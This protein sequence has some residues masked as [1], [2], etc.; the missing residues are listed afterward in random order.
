MDDE[1]SEQQEP[2][3]DLASL[4]ALWAESVESDLSGLLDKSVSI[5]VS[6][7]DAGERD[8]LLGRGSWVCSTCRSK[9][10]DSPEVFVLLPLQSALVLAAAQ[11]GVE[12]A[13]F[14]TFE[15]KPFE[16]D[17]EQGFKDAMDVCVGIL[18]RVLDE[19][20]GLPALQLEES[21]AIEAGDG[22]DVPAAGSYRRARFSFEIKGYPAGALD[23]LVAAKRAT[24]WFGGL[25]A[26]EAEGEPGGAIA[27]VDPSAESRDAFA[28]LADALGRDLLTL[29]PAELEDHTF[30]E[31]SET[32]GVVLAWDLGG[33]SALDVLERL[34]ADEST[35]DL[36][37]AIASERLTRAMVDAARRWGAE[38]VLLKPWDPEEIRARL[39]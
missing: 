22:A 6:N 8:K 38:T 35:A 30:E 1:R 3:R 28:E 15:S 24:E 11:T 36:S 20:A 29:D 33:R 23:V 12:E 2:N 34:R 16:G 32:S 21:R 13:D 19:E 37:I 18:G 4:G 25:D 14:A 7:V 9:E 10:T 27:L 39:L 26:S 31:L 5:S 17:V